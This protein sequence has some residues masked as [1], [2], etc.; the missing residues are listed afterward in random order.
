MTR[1][2]L[3]FLALISFYCCANA[4]SKNDS[5][6]NEFNNFFKPAK[7]RCIGP[8]RGGRS[9]TATGVVGNTSTYYMGSTGGG[10]WKTEDMVITWGNISDSF[11]K[12]G[13]VGAVSVAE[14]DP[15][16]VYVGMGEHAVRNVMTSYGDGVYK[17][18][19]AGKT[20]KKM[21]LDLT[22][23]IARIVITQKI[24]ILF[25]WRHKEH[26]MVHL[27]NVEFIKQ[28]MLA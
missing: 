2:S 16:I 13:S 1:R 20:W 11:F 14:S 19:D 17:S 28:P 9:V 24:P 7:W 3:L 5:V 8:F 10:V 25:L 15:N 26:Y 23:Q 12:M 6:L 4:Q 18:T 21:G 22:Q 27:R